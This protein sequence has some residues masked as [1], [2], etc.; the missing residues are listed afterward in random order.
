MK[1]TC[2]STEWKFRHENGDY[3]NVDLPHDYV[4]ASERLGHA[5]GERGIGYYQYTKG[6]YAKHLTFEEGK[7]YILNID[8]AYM[9]STVY[10]NENYLANHPHGYTPYLVDLTDNI[11]TNGTNK[12]V[13]TTMPISGSAR[14]YSGAGLYRD[15]FL[16]EGGDIRMEPWDMFI[17]TDKI[18]AGN[19]RIKL[20]YTVTADRK[21]DIEIRFS[22]LFD[23]DTVKTETAS[24]CIAEK[25]KTTHECFVD[26]KNPN[27]WDIDNPNLY[28]LKTEIFENDILL[29][30]SYNEFGI[31]T[32]S[33]DA[34]NGLLLNGK[35]I[36]LRGG[37]I[38]HD[39]G[40]L[41]AAAFPAAEMRKIRL[42][43][44]AGFN[45]RQ[46]SAQPSVLGAAGSLRPIGYGCHGRGV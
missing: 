20:Q 14:W 30:T 11:R 28:T 40:V 37:C 10:L 35:A 3:R 23:A 15:V 24:V 7:H 33:A 44:E 46:N 31:R 22:F 43:K 38:H 19:A 26:I 9:C 13:I 36:K 41:G 21:A 6:I 1:K 27:L 5:P 2:I 8:G 18:T 29:D 25:S 45:A 16:W 4:I 32:I 42:L 17:S 34:E 39:H 12:L